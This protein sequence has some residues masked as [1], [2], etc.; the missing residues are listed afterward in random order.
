MVLRVTQERFATEVKSRLGSKEAYVMPCGRRT[1]VTAGAVDKDF[2]IECEFFQ[3]VEAT[4]VALTEEGLEPHEGNW[5]DTMEEPGPDD[6]AAFIV[7]VAYRSEDSTPGIWVDADVNEINPN[8]A[9]RR[10][11]E[12]F[13]ENGEIKEVSFDQFVRVIRPN[14]LIV[15]P[16]Q[17]QAWTESN[18]SGS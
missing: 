6:V 4:K 10:M 17:I 1:R 3:G 9:L 12:E 15:P 11:Y 5:S 7:A 13:R 18:R 16:H 8:E 2:V 14:V